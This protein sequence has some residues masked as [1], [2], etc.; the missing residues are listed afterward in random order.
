MRGRKTL[1]RRLIPPDAV[2][3]DVQVAKLI[4]YVMRDGKKSLA[5]RLVYGA[6]EDVGRRSEKPPAEVLDIAMKKVMPATEVK[7]RR[8]GGANYQVP[9]PVR[10]ER[11]SFL[12]SQWILE[13]AHRKKGRSFAKKLADEILAAFE[14]TGDAFKKKTEVQRM[15]DANRAFAHFARR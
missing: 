13:A 14:G 5:E 4:R 3:G 11:R 1:P 2:F 15:A 10:G 12:A 9:I 8:V 6:L 7:S